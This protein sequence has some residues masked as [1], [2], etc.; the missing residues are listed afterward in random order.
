MIFF[1][2]LPVSALSARLMDGSG[3]LSNGSWGGVL[4]CGMQRPAT[5][6]ITAAD[7][8]SLCGQREIVTHV[9]N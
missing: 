6:H 4:P 2:L 7:I 1:F 8:A 3:Q 9:G 5:S